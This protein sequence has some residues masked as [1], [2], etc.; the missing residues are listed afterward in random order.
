[1]LVALVTKDPLHAL[2]VL[3]IVI[4]VQQ[5]EGHVLQP[6]IMGRAVSL[7]PSAVILAI[8]TGVVAAGIVGGLVAVPLLAVGNTAVRYLVAHPDGE[9]TPDK[10]PPGTEPAEESD[11]G[12]IASEPSEPTPPPP[13]EDLPDA[14]TSGSTA[15]TSK[16]D[17]AHRHT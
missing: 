16:V 6:L 12:P 4:A 14:K 7:H 1:M 5:L 9:P 3:A 8:T 11:G 13:A 17:R 10:E 15:P 2:L